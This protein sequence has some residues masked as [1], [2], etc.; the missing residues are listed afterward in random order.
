MKKKPFDIVAVKNIKFKMIF[1]F[2]S[3]FTL[4]VILLSVL[5]IRQTNIV[6]TGKVSQL[7]YE[8]NGQSCTNLNTLLVQVETGADYMKQL[9]EKHNKAIKENTYTPE[10]KEAALKQWTD[11]FA[12]FSAI[13][14][15]NDLAIIYQDGTYVGSLN[16]KTP[17]TFNVSKLYNILENELIQNKYSRTW[18]SGNND[19]FDK[20]YYTKK[21]YTNA[22][23]MCSLDSAKIEEFVSRPGSMS[24]ET[25]LINRQNQ[26]IYSS[27]PEKLGKTIPANAVKLMEENRR[28]H[29]YQGKLYTL[30]T[31]LD[32]WK[33]I[34]STEIK[35]LLK[36]RKFTITYVIILSLFAVSA[37]LIFCIIFSLQLTIPIENLIQ[38]LHIQATRDKTTRFLN[39]TTFTETCIEKLEKNPQKKE[40]LFFIDI[41][42]FNYLMEFLGREES[43]KILLETA[44]ALR[45]VF[46]KSTVFG[47]LGTDRFLILV[48][49]ENNENISE[50]I[51]DYCSSFQQE[52]FVRFQSDFD[53]TASIGISI[54]PDQE[55]RYSLLLDF[56]EKSMNSV[57]E[58]GRNGWHIFNPENDLKN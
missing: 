43:D 20:I 26:V 17:D 49:V 29:F 50:M 42:H 24:M 19:S 2:T 23:F 3:F 36:E 11:F 54:F 46:P 31:C 6:L 27:N 57:K 55:K 18:I 16:P 30:S 51:S 37:I 12:N 52:L 7:E 38:T 28:E 33:L 56:A 34:N 58:E 39:E 44:D 48:E 22:I 47:R 53:V 13:R 41:D 21:I 5:I 25:L 10:E 15:Y 4:I 9:T 8:L 45:H 14:A 35:E 40:A 1:W 32:G